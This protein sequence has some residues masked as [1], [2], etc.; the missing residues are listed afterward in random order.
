MALASSKF[1]T[2]TKRAATKVEEEFKTLFFFFWTAFLATDPS[3]FF[4]CV[5]VFGLFS[6]FGKIVEG[7]SSNNIEIKIGLS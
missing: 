1:C 3:F 2:R 4:C 6:L 7:Y 5:A